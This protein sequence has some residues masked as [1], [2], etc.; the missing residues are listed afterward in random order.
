MS[1]K[2]SSIPRFDKQA[3][4]LSKKY[5]SFKKD[6]TK[7]IEKLTNEPEQGTPL[8]GGFF[9]IRLA[10]TSK[11]KGKSRGTRVVTYVKITHNTVFLASIFDKSEKSTITDKELEHLFKLIP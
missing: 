1:Y 2:I 7:L 9:K 10:I 5:P 11:G 3:K 6:L 4:R 8:G